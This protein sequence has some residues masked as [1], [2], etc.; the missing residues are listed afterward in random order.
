M[1]I[2]KL[3]TLL[4]M[5]EEMGYDIN[6]LKEL[7]Q[8]ECSSAL[9]L[10]MDGIIFYRG[11]NMQDESW[12]IKKDPS[13]RIRRSK[14]SNNISLTFMSEDES[15]RDIQ[16]RNRSIVFTNE[17][18]NATNY[19]RTVYLVFPLDGA[20]LSHGNASD[21]YNNFNLQAATGLDRDTMYNSGIS[22][23][24]SLDSAIDDL[25]HELGLSVDWRSTDVDHIMDG[26]KEVGEA[27]ANLDDVDIRDMHSNGVRLLVG[28]IKKNGGLIETLRK[29]YDPATNGIKT[30][31][32]GDVGHLPYDIEIWTESPCILVKLDSDRNNPRF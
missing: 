2:I 9:K 21:N 26:L 22:G 11:A 25:T 31:D 10:Y 14:D 18:I 19:G 3:K 1:K 24:D 7:L 4:P 23:V 16:R 29:M 17:Y 20:K 6:H 5:T 13:T 27:A 32:I 8:K 30:V 12:I 15:W 28:Q